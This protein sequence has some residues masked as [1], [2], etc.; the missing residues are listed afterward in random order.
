M[1]S[2]N[3]IAFCYFHRPLITSQKVIS[4][5]LLEMFESIVDVLK[6]PLDKKKENREQERA[7]ERAI[8]IFN[9]Q[10]VE[11]RSWI[12]NTL[13]ASVD[14]WWTTN[15]TEKRE[16]IS[17][18]CSFFS[19]LLGLSLAMHWSWAFLL[20]SFIYTSLSVL[21]ARSHAV[22]AALLLRFH[23]FNRGVRIGVARLSTTYR[24]DKAC[25]FGGANKSSD[26]S[27]R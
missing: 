12:R 23:C 8:N 1:H 20:L 6:S 25:Q 9:I 7:S 14:A 5:L 4:E 2:G 26:R 19:S 27:I 10:P 22:A 21:S 3:S 18:S 15:R 17:I 16:C 11:H 13:T 24:A